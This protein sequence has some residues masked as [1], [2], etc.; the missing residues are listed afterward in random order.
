MWAESDTGFRVQS[1]PTSRVAAGERAPESPQTPREPE[2]GK[3]IRHQGMPANAMR[4]LISGPPPTVFWWPV[5][6]AQPI[7]EYF[8][9]RPRRAGG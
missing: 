7:E 5:G 9:V 2:T 3:R 1:G 6:T 4:P 8:P